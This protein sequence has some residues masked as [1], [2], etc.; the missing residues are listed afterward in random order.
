MMDY[1][2]QRAINNQN[3][4]ERL[5]GSYIQ[6]QAAYYKKA[7]KRI[8]QRLDSLLAD[9]GAGVIPS[10]TELWRMVKYTNLKQ[11]IEKQTKIIGRLQMEDIDEI[12]NRVYEETVGLSL[13]DFRG[14]GKFNTTSAEQTKQIL[15]AAF[16]DVS[17]SQKVWGGTTVGARIT[18][19]SE[20]LAQ[21][22]NKDLVDMICLG[23]NPDSIKQALSIDF[24]TA[25]HNA[26]RLI[27]T[28]ANHI[29]NA[30]AKDSYKAAGIQRVEFFPEPDCCEDCAEYKGIYDIDNVPLLPIH[31]NCRCCYIP[32]VE[33]NSD[34]GY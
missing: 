29:Y 9:M 10:R 11:E 24:E 6:R 20:V 30:A 2:R 22:I 14:D 13:R 25:Y 18:N 21:R 28:E 15:N 19:N 31:P 7:H 17:Y 1:W 27:R 3:K 23:K 26:D 8:E 16:E 5:S 12:A 4:A 32:I 34:E 33:L